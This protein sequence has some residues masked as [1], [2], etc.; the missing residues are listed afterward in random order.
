MSESA[1]LS[2]LLVIGQRDVTGH[3]HLDAVVDV[4]AEDSP[5]G[6]VPLFGRE[7]VDPQDEVLVALLGAVAGQV[8][9]TP[10]RRHRWPATP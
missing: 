4:V 9:D 5:E 10:D 6:V 8:L 3:D 7:F 2:F 1:G